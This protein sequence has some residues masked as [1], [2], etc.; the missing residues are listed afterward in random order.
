MFPINPK[1][2]DGKTEWSITIDKLK[3]PVYVAAH[4]VVWVPWQEMNKIFNATTY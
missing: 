4:C 1:D 3:A 2:V